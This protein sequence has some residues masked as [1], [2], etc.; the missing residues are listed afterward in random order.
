MEKLLDIN[1]MSNSHWLLDN[2]VSNVWPNRKD[3]NSE[4]TLINQKVESIN[5]I[6][7]KGT[8][9]ELNNTFSNRTKLIEVDELVSKS[10]YYNLT[11]RRIYTKNV[12]KWKGVII[13]ISDS[14]FKARLYEIGSADATYETAEFN[15]QTDTTEQD[16]EL[17]AVGA[18]F[19]WSVGNIIKN[20]TQS[21]ISE[22]RLRRIADISPNEFD[23]L[24]DDLTTKY[25]NIEWK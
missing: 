17:I 14:I 1:S 3:V 13:S 20:R 25:G 5:D 9:E 6:L 24:H 12:V 22:I 2:D 15:I 10:S 19:Y 11:R 21:K 7:E 18:I 23:E 16:R 4:I 8:D